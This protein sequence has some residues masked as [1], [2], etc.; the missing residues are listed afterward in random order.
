L[1]ERGSYPGVELN[2]WT[3]AVVASRTLSGALLL[4]E[5]DD[6]RGV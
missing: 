6:L 4:A 2:G 3:A 1:L 5:L